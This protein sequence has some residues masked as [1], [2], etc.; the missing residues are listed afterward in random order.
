VRIEPVP[1]GPVSARSGCVVVA[2][3]M[4]SSD[5]STF[6]LTSGASDSISGS[7]GS[8]AAHSAAASAAVVEAS[9]SFA[10]GAS[11][12]FASGA[13]VFTAPSSSSSSSSV[14]SVLP[15]RPAPFV[16]ESKLNL[17]EQPR[18]RVN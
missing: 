8:G 10:S 6:S 12:S 7:T 18:K 17:P 13:S 4:A 1:C 11:A 2:S 14:H 16:A 5:I 15:S 3:C 9:A